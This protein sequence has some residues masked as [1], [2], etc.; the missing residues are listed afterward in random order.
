VENYEVKM[1]IISLP[2][3]KSVMATV[4]RDTSATD[5]ATW[6]R[7]L[8]HLGDTMLKRLVDSNTIRGMDITDMQLKGICE[9]CILGKMDEKPIENHEE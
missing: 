6:H 2:P 5:L 3:Q 8:G 9:D 1:K 7:R 4:K